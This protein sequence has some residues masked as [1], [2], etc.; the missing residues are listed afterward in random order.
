MDNF[1]RRTRDNH[2]QAIDSILNAPA[3]SEE[4]RRPFGRRPV[5]MD[6]LRSTSGRRVDDF[7]RT[8]GYHVAQS[9]GVRASAPPLSAM[10]KPQATHKGSLLHMTLPSGGA[11]GVV[12]QKDKRTAKK[13]HGKRHR[14]RTFRKWALRSTAVLVVLVLLAGG[15]LITK[16][17]FKIHKVFKGGGT[18][19]ALQADVKPELLRGEGDGRVNILLMGKG[20]LGHDGPDL[21]DTMLLA[22][23]DPVNK[24]ATLVSIPRDLWVSVGSG[25]TKI[26]A[27]YA[28]AKNRSLNT[29]PK[30]TDKAQRA[31]VDAVEQVVSQ[32]LGVPVHYYVMVDFAGFKQ[33]VDTVGGVDINVPEELAVSEWLWDET[34]G[35]NY[36]L[37]VGAG[38]QH[39]DSTRALFFT[40]S[41]HTSARGDFDR[42]ERQRLFIQ[43]LSHKVLSAGT[44]TN[45][46]KLSQLMDAFGNH[47]ATDFSPNSALRLADIGK[48]IGNNIQSIGLADPPN[49]YVRT[50]NVD[51]LSVV[52][53]RAGFGDYSEIQNYIRNTLK[54]PYL[55]KENATVLVLN[56]T[57]IAGLATKQSDMLKGYGYNVVG[58]A[59]APTHDYANTI[60]VD[61]T[62]GK[63][64]FTKNYLE[65]RLDTK[66]TVRLPDSTIQTNNADYVIILGN[67]ASATQ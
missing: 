2:R 23:I 11:L 22:S 29:A 60:L 59:D 35:K 10:P 34:T 15:F 63:K 64:P 49:N 19:A 27:V 65:K 18:A 32:V 1:R 61:M 5:Q 12:G 62:G 28:N 14:L 51:G 20:G 4:I 41:R 57:D 26:N 8:E 45:P 48:S 36:H 43:A 25:S 55:A 24:S 21:T 3:R 47:V 13:D 56:G 66:A 46:V 50:D 67:N 17:A 53:P 52:R 37:Q 16:G 39:F 44:Y 7:R 31:G 38:M 9:S 58:A 6:G 42:A 54:D 30:D 33:A 40:R